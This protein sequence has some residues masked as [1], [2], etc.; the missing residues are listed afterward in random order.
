M[1]EKDVDTLF[2]AIIYEVHKFSNLAKG[3][4]TLRHPRHFIINIGY[5]I[6][7]HG[8]GDSSVVLFLI[9][10]SAFSINYT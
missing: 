7:D 10:Y 8:L 3:L 5:F 2:Y 9:L 1:P 6:I 4:L